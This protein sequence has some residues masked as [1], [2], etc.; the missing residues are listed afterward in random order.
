VEAARDE[1]RSQRDAT[2]AQLEQEF[3][4]ISDQ[5][6]AALTNERQM[7][8]QCEENLTEAQER[9]RILRRRLGDMMVGPEELATARTPDGKILTAVPGDEVVY[10]DLGRKDGLTLGLQ[11][12]VYSADVGI[13]E[14]GR[15]KAQ[16]E[17]VS[18][19]ATTAECRI[20]R[21]G[22]HEVILEGD[23]V[24]NPIFDP[25]RPL[26]FVIAGNF[27]LDRDG[28]VDRDG[29]AAIASLVRNWGGQVHTEITPLTDFVV[30]GAPP[31][32]P[33]PDSEVPADRVE[34]N[35]SRREAWE[36]YNSVL[37]TGR[38]LSIPIMTQEVF[39]N[40]LGYGDRY[41]GR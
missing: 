4:T 11:F 18:I 7:R 37:E 20:V 31:R 8:Q 2:L 34:V 25:S 10:I 22:R 30:V 21:Q 1:Y 26:S 9:F 6:T 29:A 3:E 5:N 15:S 14:D 28:M 27:D 38:S 12:A 16:I 40:F 17:V 24:A 19:N 13:P 39:L 35:K 23:L 36:A 32:R 33:R 41:A